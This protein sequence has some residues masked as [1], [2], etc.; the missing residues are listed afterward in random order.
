MYKHS[1]VGWIIWGICLPVVLVLWI[2]SVIYPTQ[3][4]TGPVI[5]S[6]AIII[7]LILFGRLTIYVDNDGVGFYFGPGII[8][9]Y[10]PFS[11]IDSAIK[12]RNHWFWGWGIR[13][14]GRGWLYNVS[15]LDS[16]EIRLKS[17][18]VLRIGTDE[19]DKLISV[20]KSKIKS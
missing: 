1:Q 10:F 11:Q 15:G 3:M 7:A 19:P 9:K 6:I 13:W 18:K 20:L 14:F 12:A 5:I 4:T 17:G 2:V 8:K 16:I